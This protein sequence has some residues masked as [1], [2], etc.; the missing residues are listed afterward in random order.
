MIMEE[1]LV[2]NKSIL[3]ILVVLVGVVVLAGPASAGTLTFNSWSNNSGYN[4][5][6]NTTDNASINP[7]EFPLQEFDMYTW[8]IAP[9]NLS[10]QTIS[11]ATITINNIG[12][13]SGNTDELFMHLLDNATNL[14]VTQLEWTSN[15]NEPNPPFIDHFLPQ[16]YPTTAN[17]VPYNMIGNGINNLIPNASVNNIALNDGSYSYTPSSING[18][19]GPGLPSNFSLTNMDFNQGNG[20]TQDV[21]GNFTYTFSAAD[22]AVLASDIAN[23]NNIALGFDPDCHFWNNGI[24][25]SINYAPTG[26]AG[27]PEPATLS[28]FALGLAGLLRKRLR[29]S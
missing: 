24:T 18:V 1:R 28:L 3:S 11:S 4:N 25:F 12:N 13:W 22:L 16:Y 10:G 5:F 19:T 2:K 6:S 9:I 7:N 15:T 21:G 29:K 20:A 26:G 17:G 27:T 23:G 14:N 8:G